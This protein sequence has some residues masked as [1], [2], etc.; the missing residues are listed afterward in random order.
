MTNRIDQLEPEALA[1]PPL[2]RRGANFWI[3]VVAIVAVITVAIVVGVRFFGRATVQAAPP[4]A[5]VVTVSQPLQRE[6]DSRLQFLGQFSPV[7]RV[8]LRAQVGGTLTRIGFKDGDVVRKGDL[9]FEIDPTQYQ[10]K[11]SEA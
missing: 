6:L 8:E 2:N 10:I 7:E 1:G 11:L 9:L 5:P 4:S 3:S